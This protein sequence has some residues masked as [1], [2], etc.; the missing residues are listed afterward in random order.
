MASYGLIS[1][2]QPFSTPVGIGSG[3]ASLLA[4]SLYSCLIMLFLVMFN[5]GMVSVLLSS[6][7]VRVEVFL[8]ETCLYACSGYSLLLGFFLFPLPRFYLVIEGW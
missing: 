2:T 5:V 7:G 1:L 4:L 3:P 6:I 8:V